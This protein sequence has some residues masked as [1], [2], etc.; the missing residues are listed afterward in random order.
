MW[1]TK[2]RVAGVTGPDPVSLARIKAVAQQIELRTHLTVDIVAGSSP[3]PTRIAL[4][5]S[6]FGRPALLLSENWVK[7]GVA[8]TILDAI[9]RSSVVLF[10]LILVVCALFVA[11]SASAA[12]RGRRPEL[13]VLAA[14]GW[15]RPRLFIAVLSEVALVGLTAGILGALLAPPLAAALGLHASPGPR[16]PGHPGRGGARHRG[17]RGA[18]L[19]GRPC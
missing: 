17:R 9:D 8:V 16:R 19:A 1:G 13:G 12:V 2:H 6:R 3:A 18:G 15:T 10:V 4:S 14:L 7:K 5:A 11:N